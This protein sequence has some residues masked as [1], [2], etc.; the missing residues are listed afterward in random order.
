MLRY[1]RRSLPGFLGAISAA[2]AYHDLGKLDPDNQTALAGGRFCKLKWDHID[3]GVAHLSAAQDWMAAWLVR[4]HHAPGLPRKLNHF[5]PDRLGW[6]LRG[7][8]HDDDDWGRHQEQIARTDANLQDYLA[9]HDSLVHA[10]GVERRCPVHGVP[11]RLALSCLVDADHSDTA[12]FDTGHLPPQSPPPRWTER[13]NALCEYVRSLPC[14]VTDAEQARNRRRAAFFEAC[15]NA[16]IDA[17]MAACEGPVGLGKTTAVAAY[18]IRRLQEDGLRR[19]IVV[20]PYTNILTQTAKR[21]REAL[22]LPG[23]D[24]D[25]VVVEHHH[26]ADFDDQNDR[27]LAV[28]WQAPVVLTTS[29]SFFETLAGCDPATLRKLHALPGSGIFLDEAHAALPTKLWPQNWR[30]LQEL[31]SDWGCRLVLAS[32]SL[33]RFWERAEIVGTPTQ[34]AELLP[35]DQAADVFAAERRRVRYEALAANVV[36]VNELI[37]RVQDAP[38]PRLLILNTVQG[39]AVVARAMRLAGTDVL[40]VSTALTPRDRDRILERVDDRLKEKRAADW[41]L[42]ATSCLE[43]G[44]D[45]SFRSAF[46]ERFSAASTIQVGGRVNRHGEY[47][48]HGGGVVYDFALDDV[49]ITQH[50]AASVSAD[51][52]LRLLN[53]DELNGV[54]P[55]SVV[56][57]A[58]VEELSRRGGLGADAFARAEATRDYPEVRRQGR[59]IEADTRLVVVDPDLKKWIVERRPIRFKELLAGSVQLWATKIDKLGLAQLPGRA[60][61]YSWDQEYDPNFLGYMAGVF[62]VQSFLDDPEAQI[63]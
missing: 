25:S 23:E 2:A 29:V 49:G 30:W 48:A 38:G 18:L 50:P 52:L 6:R 63:V 28:L 7:R 55:A 21:L 44:V 8:R 47:D 54:S 61:I 12:F 27:D 33:T 10:S 58:M 56:T 16:R 32:G 19:L 22:V 5:D 3:A 59:V 53:T 60:G 37:T 51:V 42:V 57:E 62:R 31:A 41:T 15:L 34:L 45:L 17:V 40:H 4:A 13:L 24:P 14:G 46:R 26:R 36:T 35:V 39:A 9:R 11:M 43:A 20:A 1:A